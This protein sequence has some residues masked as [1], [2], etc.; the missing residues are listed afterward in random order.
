M[1]FSFPV[2]GFS[3]LSTED[4][5]TIN[6]GNRACM[7]PNKGPLEFFLAVSRSFFSYLQHAVS[8][9][10]I[11]RLFKYLYALV[12]TASLVSLDS[13]TFVP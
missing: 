9:A 7:I 2:F 4:P 6:L 3:S 13:R 11:S 10:A 12:C 8:P 5:L 1:K